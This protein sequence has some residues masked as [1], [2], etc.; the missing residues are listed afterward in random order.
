MQKVRN[1]YKILVREFEREQPL[2]KLGEDVRIILKLM[3]SIKLSQD[4]IKL[5]HLLKRIMNSRVS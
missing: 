1:Y 3:D 4:S 2:G 5:W